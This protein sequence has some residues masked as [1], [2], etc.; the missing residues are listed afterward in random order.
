MEDICQL[1]E[2][3]ALD[4]DAHDK[5]LISAKSFHVRLPLDI[6]LYAH[7]QHTAANGR[8]IARRSA[9]C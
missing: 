2:D 3:N 7:M 9:T 6:A 5:H 1:M 4:S 8:S